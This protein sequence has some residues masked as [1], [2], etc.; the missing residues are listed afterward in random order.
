MSE[1][2]SIGQPAQYSQLHKSLVH[3]H[4]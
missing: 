1:G 2:M 4:V 3:Y